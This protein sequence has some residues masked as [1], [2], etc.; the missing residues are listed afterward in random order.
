MSIIKEAFQVY[1]PK[2]H[3]KDAAQSGG[4]AT[5]NAG[6][7]TAV[8]YAAEHPTGPAT[9]AKETPSLHPHPDTTPRI[10]DV[11]QL[12]RAEFQEIYNSLPH[13]APDNPVNR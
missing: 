1:N 2:K 4:S 3:S 6:T 12:P 7:A 9:A 5:S 13:G 10:V 11:G 8:W